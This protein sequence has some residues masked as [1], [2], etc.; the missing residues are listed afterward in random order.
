MIYPELRNIRSVDL[1]PPAMPDDPLEC[2]VHFEITVGPKE[3][4]DE[5]SYTFSVVTAA[6]LARYP[7]AQWGRGKLIVPSFDWALVIT[8]VAQLLAECTRPTWNESAA[9]LA[10]ELVPVLPEQLADA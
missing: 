9:V 1:E 3:Q 6:F 2:E 7:G 8:A 5:E 4:P 10:Q